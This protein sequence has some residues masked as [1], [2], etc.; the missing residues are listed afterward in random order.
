MPIS[1][2]RSLDRISK[3]LEVILKR[4]RRTRWRRSSQNTLGKRCEVLY[5]L[6]QP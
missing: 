6:T 3:V 5:L 4:W 2:H 1:N